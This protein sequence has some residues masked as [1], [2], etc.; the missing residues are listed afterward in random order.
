MCERWRES[1]QNFYRNRIHNAKTMHF[2]D[3]RVSLG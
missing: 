3:E 2:C 1:F